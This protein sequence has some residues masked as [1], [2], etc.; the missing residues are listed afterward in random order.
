MP[1]KEALDIFALAQAEALEWFEGEIAVLRSG[2]VTPELVEKVVVEH[3]GSRTPLQGLASVSNSDA[4]TLLI[5]PWD[6]GAATA[7]AKAL[8]AANLGVQP[9]VDGK[10]I[11]L[12]FPSLT[13][14]MREQTIRTLHQHSEE[15]RVRLRQARDE[16]LKILRDEKQDNTV[17][18]DDF[19]DGKE[20]LDRLIDTANQKIEGVTQRR[21]ADIRAV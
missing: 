5:S 8:T 6:A 17:T 12:V 4:R 16:A 1:L 3:Y 21:E 7:I 10:N 19:F 13:Q 14:E 18:E 20:S 2:R 9:N 15:A 11:R